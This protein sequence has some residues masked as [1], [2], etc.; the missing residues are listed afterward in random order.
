MSG[1][2]LGSVVL[3]GCVVVFAILSVALFLPI[4]PFDN[5]HLPGRGYYDPAQMVWFLDWT[6]FAIRHGLNPFHTSYIDFPTG[7]DLGNSPSGTILGLL[8]APLTFLVG[9]VAAWNFLIRLALFL[10]AT[11]MFFVIRTWCQ[12]TEAAFFGGLIY[13]FGPYL[14]NEAQ[15][16]E[17]HLNLAFAPFLPGIVWC[18]YD[19]AVAQRHR[20]VRMGFLLGALAGVQ[21]LIDLEM[22]V[23]LAVV[24]AVSIGVAAAVQR[25]EVMRLARHFAIGL[26][27][28]GG[29]FLVLTGDLFWW[30]LF[31]PDHVSGSVVSPGALQQYSTDLLGP[32]TPTSNELLAPG[33]V[34]RAADG[35]I[36][37]NFGNGDYLGIPLIAA[38]LA[39]VIALRRDRI[40][41]A[42][43]GLGAAALI[44]SLGDRLTIDGHRTHIPLPEAVFVH[45]PLLDS[46]TPA[47][48]SGVVAVF[49]CIVLAIGFDRALRNIRLRSRTPRPRR[50]PA[51]I[52]LAVAC[53]ITIA[54]RVPIHTPSLDWNGSLDLALGTIPSG[55]IVLTYPYPSVNWDETMLWQA[56]QQ[57]RFRIV[58]GY[59]YVQGSD[60]TGQFWPH[61]VN[62]DYVQEFLVEEQYGFPVFYPPFS[63]AT[64][65][66]GAAALCLFLSDY[67]VNA[68]VWWYA[69]PGALAVRQYFET[70]LGQPSVSEGDVLI[71][72]NTSNACLLRGQ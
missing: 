67:S 8:G 18:V 10:S 59:A 70:S 13:G 72:L 21:A 36:V 20:P 16:N 29:V 41:R 25:A 55:S 33:P 3:T 22:L 2:H 57:M 19:L 6:A 42:A 26:A 40:V 27:A 28:A 44:L 15:G 4:G 69:G 5:S 53:C 71:W 66:T 31:A 50:T 47:R 23:D 51:I 46:T 32:V 12:R 64:G 24:T 37:G 43:T 38:W 54:P 7:V 60:G 48:Y 56:Q 14:L 49:F 58:G 52:G 35:F 9:P 63:E 39:T 62:P 68:V 45:L 1:R 30:M 11:S 17:A 34:A 65:P 61:L